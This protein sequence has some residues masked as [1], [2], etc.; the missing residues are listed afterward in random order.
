MWG[1]IQNTMHFPR[2]TLLACEAKTV[3]SRG[4]AAKIVAQDTGKRCT[5]GGRKGIRRDLL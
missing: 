2:Q 3:S 5:V 4:G 1:L